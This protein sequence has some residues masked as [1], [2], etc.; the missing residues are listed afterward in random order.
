M[1][2]GAVGRSE[3]GRGL[4]GGQRRKWGHL[5]VR[6]GNGGCRKVRVGK[7]AVG[8]SEMGMGAVWRSEMGMWPV[9]RSETGMGMV[10][11]QRWD[12]TD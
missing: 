10:G 1:G 4:W 12:L 8:R 7:G 5:E 3:T 2:I 9:R 6:N 11:G